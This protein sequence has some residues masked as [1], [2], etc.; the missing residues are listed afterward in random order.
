MINYIAGAVIGAIAIW[1]LIK[2]SKVF[3]RMIDIMVDGW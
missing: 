1:A 3:M 2:I